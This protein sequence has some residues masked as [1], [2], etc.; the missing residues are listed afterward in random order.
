MFR[1]M[2]MPGYVL[3]TENFGVCVR[4]TCCD[5][6]ICVYT[7]SALLGRKL[8]YVNLQA[9]DQHGNIMSDTNGGLRTP[10]ESTVFGTAIRMGCAAS[11]PC[12]AL[13]EE[14]TCGIPSRHIA[15]AQKFN[16]LTISACN[17]HGCLLAV[18]AASMG[19]ILS[20]AVSS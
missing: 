6:S 20:M 7:S 1:A 3:V 2:I 15:N 18:R 16:V 12:K 5:G 17:N 14:V 19:S 10:P 11:L 9:K 8:V 4:S 13:T